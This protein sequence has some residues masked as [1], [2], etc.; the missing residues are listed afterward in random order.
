MAMPG[1][2]LREASGRR[3]ADR[4]SGLAFAFRRRVMPAL[5]A[6]PCLP[7]SLTTLQQTFPQSAC[8]KPFQFGVQPFPPLEDIRTA[9][10]FRSPLPPAGS[11]RRSVRT[12]CRCSPGCHRSRIGAVPGHCGVQPG[13]LE[14]WQWI[15]RSPADGRPPEESALPAFRVSA[16]R[17]RSPLRM[18]R[19]PPTLFPGLE[20]RTGATHVP[21]QSPPPSFIRIGPVSRAHEPGGE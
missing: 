20:A 7:T 8:Q 13:S 10:H 11:Q 18:S 16:G 6:F 9:S 17:T 2:R 5:S 1:R 14:L 21:F 15:S 3:T 19:I 4:S 12:P